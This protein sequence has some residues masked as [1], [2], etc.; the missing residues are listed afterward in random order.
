MSKQPRKQRKAVYNAPLHA[1]RKYMGVNLS[2]DLR[3]EFGRRSL[4]VK[5]GDT[6]KVVRGE[7]KD[8]EG[9]VEKVDVKKLQVIIQGVTVTKTDTTKVFFPIHPSNLVLVDADMKDDRRNK[10]LDRGE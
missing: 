5:V 7:F 1:R 9:K 10:I 6:V 8:T 2:H 3:E 4:P